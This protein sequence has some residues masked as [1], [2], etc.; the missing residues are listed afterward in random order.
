MSIQARPFNSHRLLKDVHYSD[1]TTVQPS[2]AVGLFVHSDIRGTA[3][4]NDCSLRDR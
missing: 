2:M 3:I 1:L 4:T